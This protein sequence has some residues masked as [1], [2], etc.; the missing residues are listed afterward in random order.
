MSSFRAQSG[1]CNQISIPVQRLLSESYCLVSVGL[2]FWREDGS[3]VYSVISQRSE[4]RRTRNHTS[5]SH[6]ILA[7]HGGPGS[8]IYIPQEQGGPIIPPALRFSYFKV[9]IKVT[10]RLAVSQSVSQYVLVSS[11]LL[12]LWADTTFFPSVA[13]SKF[14][15]CLWGVLSLT[16]GRVCRLSVSVRSNLSVCT[17]C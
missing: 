8:R 9:K 4:W 12:D 10:L 13:V 15:C 6:P 5:L 1:T 14:L 3:A 2:P 16:R 17:L 7:Q 11:P